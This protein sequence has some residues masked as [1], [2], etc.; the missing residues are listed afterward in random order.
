MACNLPKEG[1]E[2]KKECDSAKLCI[3][4]GFEEPLATNVLDAIGGS[5]KESAGIATAIALMGL[6]FFR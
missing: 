6:Y 1:P 2:Q 4:K 3:E 5:V